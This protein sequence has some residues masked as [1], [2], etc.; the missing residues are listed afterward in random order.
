MPI[1]NVIG[2]CRKHY[3][4]QDLRDEDYELIYRQLADHLATLDRQAADIKS[5]R[6]VLQ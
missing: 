3:A 2:T 4:E 1:R 6:I 5:G